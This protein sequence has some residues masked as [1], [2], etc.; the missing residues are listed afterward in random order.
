MMFPLYYL[1]FVDELSAIGGQCLLPRSTA[2][3]CSIAGTAASVRH[4][5]FEA[6]C[7]VVHR[8]FPTVHVRSKS[9]CLGSPFYIY[10]RVGLKDLSLP[11]ITFPLAESAGGS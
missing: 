7:G 3:A 6:F 4:S 8:P 10:R 9:T 2:D 5:T 1:V 11:R